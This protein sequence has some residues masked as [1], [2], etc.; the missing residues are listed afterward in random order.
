MAE[1]L[2]SGREQKWLNVVLGK[3]NRSS[4]ILKL[5]PLPSMQIIKKTSEKNPTVWHRIPAKAP[6]HNY[7]INLPGGESVTSR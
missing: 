1:A 2:P 7:T 3:K 5:S 6:T 4:E